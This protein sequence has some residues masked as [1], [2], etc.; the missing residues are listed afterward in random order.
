MPMES[1]EGQ[2]NRLQTEQAPL[3]S[4]VIP[5]YNSARFLKDC[6][7]SALSQTYP[8]IEI[9]VVDDGS[10]DN[11][12]EVLHS[13]NGSI[14]VI[15]QVNA[16]VSAARNTGIGAAKG[17]F[18]VMLDADDTMDPN[19]I[20]TRMVPMLAD[21]QVGIVAG[22]YR[23]AD[24]N[25]VPYNETAHTDLPTISLDGRSAIRICNSPNIGL[26]IRKRAFA[27]CGLYDPFFK[28]GEDWDMQIRICQKFKHVFVPTRLATYRQVQSSATRNSVRFYDDGRRV[29]QKTRAYLGNSLAT[30]LDTWVGLFHHTVGGVFGVIR[31][32]KQGGGIAG[33]I[34][35]VAKRPSSIV[36]LFAGGFRKIYNVVTGRR[37]RAAH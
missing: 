10:T 13:Y 6:I 15:S 9:I 8:S 32:D 3:V 21:P 36:F 20:E 12:Q 14:R 2:D 5:C 29:M 30:R 31:A 17:D 34:R 1:K 22:S 35:F 25:L 18:V 7:D 19:C 4:V 33:L 28:G 26:I 27:I 16:G 23:I 11:S 24:E 37:K